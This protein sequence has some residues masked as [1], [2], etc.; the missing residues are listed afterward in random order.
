MGEIEDEEAGD[1]QDAGE[2]DEED[3]FEEFH[4]RG[5]SG[6]NHRK[7]GGKRWICLIGRSVE[8]PKSKIEGRN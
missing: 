7:S 4:G 1:G 3:G 2:G 8:G 5:I 6:V